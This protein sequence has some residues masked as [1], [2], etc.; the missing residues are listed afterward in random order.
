MIRKVVFGVGGLALLGTLV[1]GTGLYSYVRTS[2]GYMKRAVHDT[3]PVEFQIDRA[4]QMVKDIMPEVERNMRLIARE[5]VEVRRLEERI[6]RLEDRLAKDRG[7]ILRLK[8]DLADGGDVFHY[9]GRSYTTDQV[10]ADLTARF[11]RFQTAD[12][13]L[14]S[15]EKMHA[16]RQRSLDAA[17]QKLEGMLAAKRQL[18]VEVENLEARRQM[19]A[20]AETTSEFQFDDSHLGRV[21]EL[22]ADLDARLDVADKMVQAET[23]FHDEIPLD[24]PSEA[25]IVEQVSQYFGEPN[26]QELA[27]VK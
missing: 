8:T 27:V 26:D 25:N 18:E 19:I 17:R 21:K 5:E 3:V 12:A 22:I 10:K 4:R 11:K 23:N 7:N 13:T 1:F 6:G 20:A 9:A 15:L 24:E 16:A 2:C 14:Q